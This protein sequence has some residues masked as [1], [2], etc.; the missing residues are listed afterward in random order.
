L[1]DA[2][3]LDHERGV[4][5]R[6]EERNIENVRGNVI[7]RRLLLGRIV[8]ERVL[9]GL[10]FLDILAQVLKLLADGLS[11]VEDPVNPIA[12]AAAA[13]EKEQADTTQDAGDQ[14]LVRF[15]PFRR[16]RRGGDR[17]LGR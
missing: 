11:G 16:R 9:S 15:P 14:T 10:I 8:G 7:V 3:R 5:V 1:D 2:R 6:M 17:S 12:D 4:E 13:G